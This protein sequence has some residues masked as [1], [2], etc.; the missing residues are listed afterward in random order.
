VQEQR[1]DPALRRRLREAE[2]G[3]AGVSEM[4]GD[5]AQ[6]AYDRLMHAQVHL[7][8]FFITLELRVE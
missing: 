1:V 8:L 7:S 3:M 2:Q 6:R 5:R 4:T